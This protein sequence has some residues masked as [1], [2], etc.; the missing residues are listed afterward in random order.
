[1][2]NSRAGFFERPRH[3]GAILARGEFLD[4]RGNGASRHQQFTHHPHQPVQF[5]LIDAN[6]VVDDRSRGPGRAGA[7]RCL[8]LSGRPPVGRDASSIC[9]RVEV[10]R[11][12]Q[13]RS[14][15]G[16]S[17]FRG[18]HARRPECAV[19][20]QQARPDRIVLVGRRRCKRLQPAL[21]GL[22]NRRPGASPDLQLLQ[23]ILEELQALRRRI[24]ECGQRR[25]EARRTRRCQPIQPKLLQK[26]RRQNEAVRLPGKISS[27]P[28]IASRA[29]RT[30]ATV[31][32][33]Q[34]DRRRPDGDGSRTDS[35]A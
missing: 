7:G 15:F 30:S 10:Q 2:G 31:R 27:R 3:Y 17:R 13:L 21:I 12:V 19:A 5:L 18:S 22:E 23:T 6:V 33:I 9:E 24:P 8:S 11:V 1:M 28:C 32:R 29:S 16:V 20:R 25:R 14:V 26:V 4:Q 34:R 35:T